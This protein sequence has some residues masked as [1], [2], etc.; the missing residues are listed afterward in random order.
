MSRR[1][2]G[3]DGAAVIGGVLIVLIWLISVLCSLM[4]TA[5]VI[6]VAGDILGL[7]NAVSFV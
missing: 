5:A 6:A 2:R 4:V 7:W 1:N 3:S